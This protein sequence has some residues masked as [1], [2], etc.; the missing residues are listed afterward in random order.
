MAVGVGMLVIAVWI[1]TLLLPNPQPLTVEAATAKV[2]GYLD[3]IES[4]LPVGSVLERSEEITQ[5]SCP[6]EERG[7]QAKVRRV[8]YV[9]PVLD[10]VSWAATLS[11]EFP[12][13][14]GWVVRVRTLDSRENL[15]I[16]I[17]GRDLIIMNL[18]ASDASGQARITMGATSECSQ[19]G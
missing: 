17:V 9:D 15:D 10:R 1:V 13:A 18:T 11:G 2:T 8:V 5:D 12:E 14:D 4:T 7:G 16:R 3:R 19:P 6:I